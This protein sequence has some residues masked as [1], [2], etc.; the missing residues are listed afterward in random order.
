MARVC[1]LA[2]VQTLSSARRILAARALDAAVCA[3]GAVLPRR[4]TTLRLVRTPGTQTL[5]V[6]LAAEANAD[7]QATVVLP[8]R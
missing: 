1:L 8:I 2:G 3:E 6:R 7:R 4:R 5:A